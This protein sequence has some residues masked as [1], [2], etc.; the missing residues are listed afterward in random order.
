MSTLPLGHRLW[1]LRAWS[2]ESVLIVLRLGGL[3]SNRGIDVE[4]ACSHAIEL[5]VR[6]NGAQL[7][8]AQSHVA[9]RIDE[10]LMDGR[11]SAVQK[12]CKT[13]IDRDMSG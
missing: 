1:L 8:G 2:L 11:L 12:L 5:A 4:L 10:G 13:L 9:E 7:V 3:L 6:L